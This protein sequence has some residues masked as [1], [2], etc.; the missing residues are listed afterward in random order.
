MKHFLNSTPSTRT[1]F[2]LTELFVGKLVVGVAALMVIAAVKQ[3]QAR[4][5]LPLAVEKMKRLGNACIMYTADNGG[6]LPFA[7]A[8]GPDDWV[9]AAN[10]EASE[11]WYNALPKLMKEKSVG[12]IGKT[13]PPAFY[14]DAYILHMPGAPYPDE[15][16]RLKK[17][18]FAVGMNSRLRRKDDVG[19]IRR[20]SLASILAPPRTVLFLERGMPLDVQ[21]SKNQLGFNASPKANPRA[22]VG[23]HGWKGI[24]LFADGHTE[25]CEFA[26]VCEENGRI[27]FPQQKFVWTHDPDDDPN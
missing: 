11:V 5:S 15:E 26:D 1:G 27:Q 13:N 9:H 23:R 22:F 16:K 17:P 2:G 3:Q 7:D 19:I 4:S 8:P 18:Y 6:L 21:V 24:L 20:T 12:E 25:A 10:P 14:K